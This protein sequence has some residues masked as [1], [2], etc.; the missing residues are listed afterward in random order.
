M[1]SPLLSVL[2]DAEPT[3]SPS[4]AFFAFMGTHSSFLVLLKLTAKALQ[5][6]SFSPA[7]V[8]LMELLR[9]AWE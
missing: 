5:A 4:A 9:P 8:L 1:A 6:L 2:A 3:T 7:L